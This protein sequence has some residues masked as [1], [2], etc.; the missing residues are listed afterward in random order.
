MM[1]QL[2]GCLEGA[3]RMRE[4]KYD[5]KRCG[6]YDDV[7]KVWKSVAVPNIMWSETA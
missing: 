7:Q 3:A 4:S 6:S 2:I 1:S 5:Y